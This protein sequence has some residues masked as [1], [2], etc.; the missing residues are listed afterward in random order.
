MKRMDGKI[1][2]SSP[3]CMQVKYWGQAFRKGRITLPIGVAFA[4]VVASG[5]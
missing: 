4:G 2:N 1:G 3:A 5:H